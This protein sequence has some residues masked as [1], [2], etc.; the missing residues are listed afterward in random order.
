M[1]LVNFLL[2][3]CLNIYSVVCE[4]NLKCRVC[5]TISKGLEIIVSSNLTLDTIK[6]VGFP[7]CKMI[8]G[9]HSCI[10]KSCDELCHGILKEYV[11]VMINMVDDSLNRGSYCYDFGICPS[12]PETPIP[13][14]PQI[15]SNLSNLNGEKDWYNWNNLTGSGYFIHVTDFHIDSKYKEGISSNC[16]L[17][18][19]CR[20][21]EGSVLL[22]NTSKLSA[23]Y[24]G[25]FRFSL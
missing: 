3:L 22:N 7:V 15:L 16:T 17:P 11:P 6:K 19:C 8:N 20:V 4:G 10:G 24:W 9:S 21:Q 13:N 25:D 12:K 18:L 2:I 23:G 1:K 5:Q 14:T